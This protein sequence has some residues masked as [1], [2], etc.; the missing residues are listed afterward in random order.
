MCVCYFQFIG[1]CK[2]QQVY[3]AYGSCKLDETE[4]EHADQVK[5]RKPL[6]PHWPWWSFWR[7]WGAC[8]CLPVVLLVIV[9]VAAAQVVAQ[10]DS[11]AHLIAMAKTKAACKSSDKAQ[12]KIVYTERYRDRERARARERIPLKRPYWLTDL[13]GRRPLF[14]PNWTMNVINYASLCGAHSQNQ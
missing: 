9:V 1:Q 6:H 12:N 13:A 10:V 5:V 7:W 8:C 14:Q 4:D 2:T 11:Y 3:K